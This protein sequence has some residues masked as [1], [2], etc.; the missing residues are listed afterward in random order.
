MGGAHCAPAQTTS[1][2]G[3][4][5]SACSA[6]AGA[7]ASRMPLRGLTSSALSVVQLRMTCKRQWWTTRSAELAMSVF[8]RKSR[9]FAVAL[10]E[11]AQP[12]LRVAA[13]DDLH[14]LGRGN[15]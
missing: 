1:T 5:A 11:A 10:A 2:A 4:S 6:A 3:R 12:V 14:G 15:S 9:A 8:F 13:V 7:G